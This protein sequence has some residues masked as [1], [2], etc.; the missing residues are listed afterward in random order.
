M[1]PDEFLPLPPRYRAQRHRDARLRMKS[2]SPSSF[3]SSPA[4]CAA[5][6]K[7]SR[8]R[9]SNGESLT[10]T[11]ITSPSTPGRTTMSICKIS[12][13]VSMN[14]GPASARPS[15]I[16]SPGNGAPLFLRVTIPTCP[17]RD[18]LKSAS[19]NIASA[20][21][22]S[23]VDRI[24]T[25]RVK[26]KLRRWSDAKK[27]SRPTK[28]IAFAN[29]RA[30]DRGTTLSAATSGSCHPMRSTRPLSRHNSPNCQCRPTGSRHASMAPFEVAAISLQLLVSVPSN[31]RRRKFPACEQDQGQLARSAKRTSMAL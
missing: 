3:H 31:F 19:S 15:I 27:R 28:S 14:L 26:K 24:V 23:S 17:C 12:Q 20:S 8:T 9:S 2:D 22:L 5:A 25:A 6:C 29:A 21:R 16:S 13:S 1:P 4:C 30:I 11:P 18:Q 7:S 10:K